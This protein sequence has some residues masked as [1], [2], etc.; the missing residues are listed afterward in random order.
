[1]RRALVLCMDAVITPAHLLFDDW[2]S[3][4]AGLAP[5][6]PVLAPVDSAVAQP[7]AV[8]APAAHAPPLAPAQPMESTHYLST[9]A[10]LT[11][12][13]AHSNE[14]PTTLEL[15]NGGLHNAVRQN[16]HQI[17]MAAIAA[18]PSRMEAARRLGISP[19]TLRYKL[20]QLREPAMALTGQGLSAA[21]AE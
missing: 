10:A 4:M 14:S 13:A 2:L 3:P 21:W 7:L 15:S 8:S 16:E 18:A 6:A 19:R 12:A 17:I 1:M 20:A 11:A 5:A 9:P